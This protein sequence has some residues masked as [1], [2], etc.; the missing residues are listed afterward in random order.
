[1]D[2]EAYALQIAE[3]VPT[4]N[5]VGIQLSCVKESQTY[6]KVLRS[7]GSVETSLFK[8]G[9]FQCG[10]EQFWRVPKGMEE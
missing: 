2:I 5:H 6:W 9:N 4:L 7:P 3:Q 8:V 1:M 10:H